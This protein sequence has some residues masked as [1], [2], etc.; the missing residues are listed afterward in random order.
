MRSVAVASSRKGLGVN[1]QG[2]EPGKALTKKMYDAA[3]TRIVSGITQPYLGEGSLATGF[4]SA[5]SA[6]APHILDK[7][8]KYRQRNKDW[9]LE[10]S[11]RTFP[12][13]VDIFKER[14]SSNVERVELFARVLEAAAPTTCT[15][16]S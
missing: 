6:V 9:A 8:I 10:I 15:P 3:I 2:D 11:L 16:K 5:L 1:E 13:G 7:A 14:L 12:E 4:V